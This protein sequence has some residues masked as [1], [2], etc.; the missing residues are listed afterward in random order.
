MSAIELLGDLDDDEAD[1]NLVLVWELVERYP[2]WLFDET[3]ARDVVVNVDT[4]K[5]EQGTKATAAIKRV[6]MITDDP[7]KALGLT[8]K[9]VEKAEK[10]NR[11][12]D[13]PAVNKML[14]M[15]A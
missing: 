15:F 5:D 3:G 2:K 11:T 4:W 14:D 10:T 12:V 1:S 13:S 6:N 7:A 8:R 9:L